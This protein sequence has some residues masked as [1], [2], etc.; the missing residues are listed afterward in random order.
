MSWNKDAAVSYLRSHALGR[1]HSECGLPALPFWL[2][3]LSSEHRL[4]KRLWG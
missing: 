2:A 1:S 4:C 3:V